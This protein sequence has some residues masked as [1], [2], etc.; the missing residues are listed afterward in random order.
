VALVCAAAAA[1]W[2]ASVLARGPACGPL[3]PGMAPYDGS[4]GRVVIRNVSTPGPVVTFDVLVAP[5]A[6]P[7]AR[8]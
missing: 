3:T 2:A 6:P 8:D 7:P 1:L 4:P 5:P